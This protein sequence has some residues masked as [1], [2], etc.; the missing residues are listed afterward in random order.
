VGV[1][2]DGVG[3]PGDRLECI[4]SGASVHSDCGAGIGLRNVR[5]RLR[6]VFGEG[7]AFNISSDNGHGTAVTL[8]IPRRREAVAS[9]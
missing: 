5:D 6:N 1:Y 4:L 7:C 8:R 2:D 3:I 9:D